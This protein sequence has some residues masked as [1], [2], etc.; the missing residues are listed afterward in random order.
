[1]FIIIA[2]LLCFASF[3]GG[4]KIDPRYHESLELTWDELRHVILATG[5]VIESER[6]GVPCTYTR[7]KKSIHGS[8]YHC[9][10]FQVRKPNATQ[11]IATTSM[12]PELVENENCYATL[13]RAA[14]AN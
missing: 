10:F 13:P 11:A 1:M 14:E 12:E 8:E 6:V 3:S 9:I 5:F 2:L 7:D 4:I